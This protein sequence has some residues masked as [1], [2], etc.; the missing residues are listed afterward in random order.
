MNKNM[1]I[2]IGVILAAVVVLAFVF[3]LP[4]PASEPQPDGKTERPETSSIPSQQGM[5]RVDMSVY[6]PLY[7]FSAEIPNGWQIAH[8]PSTD[9][10][11]IFDPAAPGANDLERSRIFIRNFEANSFLTL[12]TVDIL[13]REETTLHGHAAVR[14]EIEKKPDVPD[15]EGQPAWR[16]R[17]HKLVDV[18]FSEQNPTTFFVIAYNPELPVADFETFI[19]SIRFHNDAES[20]VQ[21]VSRAGERVT[22]KP[23]GI[24][25]TP[26]NS[27][28]Q[29]EKFSGYHTG[30]DFEILPNEADTDV[31]VSAICGGVLRSKQTA[32]GYGGVAIQDCLMDNQPVTVIYGHLRLA[33]VVGAIGEY[34]APGARIG[35]LGTPGRETD[36]ERKHLHLGIHRGNTTNIRG[37]VQTQAELG[38]WLN[39]ALVLSL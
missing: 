39:P 22:K 38:D 25:I 13:S 14:Y 21:P 29:P 8:V 16:S 4:R 15:F 5:T 28:V 24:L 20:F 17:R 32:S 3:L 7:R 34:L 12:S 27:P 33:S 10:L 26:D 2:A 23:F 19:E 36:G 11:N 35:V 37:Y 9:A 6:R 31:G 1:R 30:T 18:R